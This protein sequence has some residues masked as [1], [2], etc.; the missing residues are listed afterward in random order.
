MSKKKQEETEAYYINPLLKGKTNVEV[1]EFD[2]YFP[3][4]KD[5][6]KLYLEHYMDGWYVETILSGQELIE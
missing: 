6:K 1:H 2:K 3:H 5:G 4:L